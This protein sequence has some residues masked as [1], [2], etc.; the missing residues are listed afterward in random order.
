[1]R[2]LRRSNTGELGFS[3]NFVGKDTIPPYAILSHTWGE[4]KTL[5]KTHSSLVVVVVGLSREGSWY[6]LSHFGARITLA[7]YVW[8]SGGNFGSNEFH[9]PS[10]MP[11]EHC[12]LLTIY[13]TARLTSVASTH[14]SSKH[15]AKDES[16]KAIELD[17][18][19]S[20]RSCPMHHKLGSDR[21]IL[22]LIMAV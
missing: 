21:R 10:R 12:K 2:L 1:M 22:P 15:A 3:R 18:D 4:T 16:Q 14:S 6:M 17:Y 9:F 11:C 13:R 7:R 20:P 19:S 8:D 5:C